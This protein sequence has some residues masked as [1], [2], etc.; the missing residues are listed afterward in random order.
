MTSKLCIKPMRCQKIKTYFSLVE[1]LIVMAIFFIL[2]S[3]LMPVFDQTLKIAELSKCKN[4]FKQILLSLSS[5]SDDYGDRIPTSSSYIYQNSSLTNYVYD[6]MSS[7]GY[8]SH[9]SGLGILTYHEYLDSAEVLHCPTEINVSQMQKDKK[10]SHLL[11]QKSSKGY[12]DAV[13]NGNLNWTSTYCYR[14]H[15]WEEGWPSQH[16]AH[17]ISP[18]KDQPFIPYLSK[19]SCT[20]ASCGSD[21]HGT[22]AIISDDFS[23]HPTKY[24]TAQGYFHHQDVYNVGYTDGHVEGI[25]DPSLSLIY[26]IPGVY[27][28]AASSILAQRISEDIWDAFDGDLTMQSMYT[29]QYNYG[30]V[31]GLK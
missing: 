22:L 15:T 6:Q 17:G 12:K 1:L 18:G 20:T 19:R 5:Y 8:G 3:L 7:V 25:K 10:V 31:R 13:D 14:G 26:L 27:S 29:S 2:I 9:M 11:E 30:R 16:P 21:D 23:Y 24:P 28:A 4:H